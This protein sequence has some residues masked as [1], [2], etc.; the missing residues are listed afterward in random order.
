MQISI[1][2]HSKEKEK[3]EIICVCINRIINMKEMN[4]NQKPIQTINIAYTTQSKK[5]T[6]FLIVFFP[7]FTE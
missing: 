5:I 3:K 1:A 7:F 6:E 2:I 4:N